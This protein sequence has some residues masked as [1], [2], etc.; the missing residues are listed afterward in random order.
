MYIL[1]CD[2]VINRQEKGQTGGYISRLVLAGFF[3]LPI[4]THANKHGYEEADFIILQLFH[5][6]ESS[7]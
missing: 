5:F 3:P 2:M 7:I 4:I 1:T 6:R